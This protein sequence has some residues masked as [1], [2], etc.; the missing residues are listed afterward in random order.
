M[1][2]RT[3]GSASIALVLATGPATGAAMGFGNTAPI[4]DSVT[5]TPTPVPAGSAASITCAAHDSGTVTAL[6]VTVSGGALAGAGTSAPIAISP[7][8]S[9]TGS[10]AWTTP[11]TPGTFTVT[12]AATD[13]GG[14][15][16]ASPLTTTSAPLAITTVAAAPPPVIDSL[17][18][19]AAPVIAGTTAV[20]TATAHDPAGEGLTYAWRASGGTITGAGSSATWVAPGAAGSF[21][22]TVEVA[23]AGGQS[24]SSSRAVSVVLAAYQGGLP[25]AAVAPRRLAV[26]ER[27]GVYAVDAQGG[28][29]LL[30]PRGEVKGAVPL[31]EIP[32]A[33]TAGPGVL[34]ISTASGKLYE[35]SP[36][37][38]RVL[39]EIPLADGPLR[40]STGLVYEPIHMLIWATEKAADRVRAVRPDGTTA[41]VV[42]AAGA[43]PLSAPVDVALDAASGRIWVA[44]E[45]ARSAV[46]VAPAEAQELGRL[47]HGFDLQG[48]YLGSLVP[49]GTRAGEVTRAGGLA[50]GKAGELYVSDIFQGL[51]QVFTGGG[52][53][54]GAIGSFGVQAGQLRT[55]LGLAFLGT[56]DVLVANLGASRID[57]FGVGT[58]LPACAG[59]ADCDG[60][61]DAWEAARG[62]NPLF[63]GD[64]LL[65]PDRDGLSNAE[66]LARGTD[67][68]NPDSDGDGYSDGEEV[69]AGLDPRDANDHRPSLTVAGPAGSGP[70]LVELNATVVGA[71]TCSVDWT[72]TAGPRVALGG[73]PGTAPSYVARVAGT[74]RF[75]ARATCGRSASDA[76]AVQTV[77]RNEP[78]VADAGGGILVVRPGSTVALD[79]TASSDANGDALTFAW[80]QVL[81]APLASWMPGRT[82][83]VKTR[84]PGYHLFELT[85]T[86]AG[87]EQG[88]T[89]VPVLVAAGTAPT[90]IT[91]SPLRGAAGAAVVLD[92]TASYAPGGAYAFEW[93]QRSGPP[94]AITAA[95]SAV[96]RVIPPMPGRY[97]F[98]VS[99]VGEA[100][101]SPPAVVDLYVGDAEGR[102]PTAAATRVERA[103]VGVSV[104]L[105]GSA[106][107]PAV[108]GGEL[109]Y[110]WRQVAGP[111]A[112]LT[113]ET[114][115][116][117]TVVAFAPGSHVFELT[118]RDGQSE[119]LPAR[120]RLDVDAAGRP[121]PVAVPAALPAMVAVGKEVVLD[122]S[123]SQGGK[124]FRWTQVAGPWAPL[125]QPTSAAARFHAT[126]AGLYAFELVVATAD[127]V[128][129]APATVSVLVFGRGQEGEE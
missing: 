40:G 57:R 69:L 62:L 27:G 32:T 31:P 7:A 101:R 24:V 37:T 63:A 112:G 50:V 117:A 78:P 36:G 55:P 104:R 4:I 100:G 54:R 29:L 14:S 2:L 94:V 124:T 114:A 61:P 120:V 99:L 77:V 38:G 53:S 82:V 33:V 72:Q 88:S 9:V 125:D 17:S 47:V 109:A 118:V 91:S 48:R 67:P 64:A 122:G 92:A 70:G 111:A 73:N 8:A 126:A 30:T 42:A 90:A 106:S 83:S 22:V 66:E 34:F 68:W 21:A 58:A 12:C 51:V 113:H 43:A 119:S 6:V 23:N 98:D 74:Y 123:K 80:D 41:L 60:L 39:R 116:I 52:E 1:R 76:A 45:L 103:S 75:E 97:A 65:D 95:D 5:V 79:A 56:G 20:F 28:L 18:G 96:A 115:A 105:D 16:G 89:E 87:G 35:A 127:G 46:D 84:G 121:A 102:L 11:A 19:P 71:G 93:R 81:G 25:A 10:I 26:D 44:L 15:F 86:D 129:S 110:R 3:L 107:A 85:A 128:R 13:A 108:A 49:A 59:D